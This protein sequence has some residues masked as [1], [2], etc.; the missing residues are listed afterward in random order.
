MT[1][2]GSC[3]NRCK[4]YDHDTGLRNKLL[5]V[6]LV[7]SNCSNRQIMSFWRDWESLMHGTCCVNLRE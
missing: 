2:N 3:S 7:I 4:L 5:N 6:E 1:I